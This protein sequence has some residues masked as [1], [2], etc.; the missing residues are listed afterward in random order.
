MSKNIPI[1]CVHILPISTITS[2]CGKYIFD[3]IYYYSFK[4]KKPYLEVLAILCRALI[5]FRYDDVNCS[6]CNHITPF[7]LYL[8][9]QY[10]VNI[11][12]YSLKGENEPAVCL[13]REGKI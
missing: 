10:W 13:V 7:L 2:T 12:F 4:K 8:L 3:S 9:L 6:V 5:L 11:I 1:D